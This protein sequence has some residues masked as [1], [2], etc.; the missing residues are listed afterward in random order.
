[1]SP[2]ARAPAVGTARTVRRLGEPRPAVVVAAPDGRPLSVDGERV[3]GV[4]ETWLL[5]DRWWTDRPLRRRLWEVVTARGRA[6]VVHRDLVD[7]R[8]WRSR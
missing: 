4:V 1:M 2:A 7:G 5:E 6:I 3:E 8:W